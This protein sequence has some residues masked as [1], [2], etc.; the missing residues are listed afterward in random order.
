MWYNNVQNYYVKYTFI[1]GGFMKAVEPI[2]D[3]KNKCYEKLSKG[4]NIRD[5]TLFVMV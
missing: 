2:R 4:K 5:Y 1:K 3:Q